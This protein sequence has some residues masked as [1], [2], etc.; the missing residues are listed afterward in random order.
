MYRASALLFVSLSCCSRGTEAPARGEPARPTGLAAEPPASLAA[1]AL[2]SAPDPYVEVLKLASYAPALAYARPLMGD[3]ANGMSLGAKV[4]TVWAAKRM[5]LADVAVVANETSYLLVQKDSERER[6]KRMCVTGRLIE[7][8]KQ[9]QNFVPEAI[10]LGGM[11]MGATL[12]VVRFAAVGSTEELVE[13]SVGRFCGLVA[14]TYSYANS[15]GGVT[16]A[17]SMI[18]M[19][20]LPEN[21]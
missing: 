6:G 2:P 16:H 3:A 13:S 21:R 9:Q 14:G 7:I 15:G 11:F 17:V 20:D 5:R 12:H 10:F 19:F 8:Q 1:P 4:M 18:G